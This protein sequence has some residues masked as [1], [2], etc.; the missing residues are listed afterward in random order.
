MGIHNEMMYIDATAS[1]ICNPT[2]PLIRFNLIK[3]EEADYGT[4]GKHIL[5]FGFKENEDA[6][7]VKTRG[8]SMF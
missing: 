2:I 7:K 4:I 6:N 1:H 5:N 8:E 3:A